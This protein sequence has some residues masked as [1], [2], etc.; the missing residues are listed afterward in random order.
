MFSQNRK[1]NRKQNRNF[2]SHKRSHARLY[3]FV[4]MIIL[5]VSVPVVVLWQSETIQYA[6]LDY[7]DLA[8]TATPFAGER[9]AIGE[10]FYRRGDI[11][12]AEDY[13]QLSVE[14]QPENIDYMYEHG[15]LLIE[16]DRNEEAVL[17]GERL[18]ELAPNDPRG[19]ALKANAIAW[20]N[21]TEAIPVAVTGLE[22]DSNFAPLHGALAASYTRIGRYT[23]AL[24][25][26]DLAVRLDPYDVNIRRSFSLPLIYTG[27]YSAAIQ[28]L[29]QAIAINP[30]I[31]APYFELAALYRNPLIN[32]PEYAVAI[33]YEILNIEPNNERAYLRLCE[34]YAA[35]GLFQEAEVFCEAALDINPDYAD[36]HRMT[37]QLRYSRR[38]YEG[39]IES[40]DRCQELS[41]SNPDN[42]DYNEVSIE[43]IYILGLAHYFLA[44]NDHCE[45]AWYW[46]NIA[47]NH[48][49]AESST[50]ANILQGLENTTVNCPG[51]RGRT[52]PTPIPP[53][54][55]PPTPIGGY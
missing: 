2:F 31:V 18:M 45:L 11:Q 47:L 16:L 55:I 4:I 21:P 39:A 12:T 24:R 27:N 20:D 1:I 35:A 15:L 13:F 7:F 30:N 49:E 23:E 37:G 32:Q 52:L 34:T 54:P 22:V 25:E 3:F 38:N 5:I 6:A 9:A 8:P 29:E 19:Y 36:A 50:L 40:F 43:C 46:L 17:H 28:Q 51:Y 26:G 44:V 14:Q 10:E 42:P 33:F 48:P 41:I 53:T